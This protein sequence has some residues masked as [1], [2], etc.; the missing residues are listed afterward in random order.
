[1]FSSKSTLFTPLLDKNMEKW[2][3]NL[4]EWKIIA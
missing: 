4:V 1:M 3:E 2:V